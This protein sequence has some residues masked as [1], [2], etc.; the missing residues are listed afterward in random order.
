[1]T[2]DDAF[3]ALAVLA[4]LMLAW[5]L[6]RPRPHEW[7][8][9]K[10]LRIIE[11]LKRRRDALNEKLSEAYGGGT[12]CPRCL[13]WPWETEQPHRWTDTTMPAQMTCGTCGFVS[14]WIDGPGVMLEVKPP[15]APIYIG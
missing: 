1:M 8:R 12:R 6:I 13:R 3:G 4:V 2:V 11:K 10:R 9:K 14:H 7:S 5:N 15:L